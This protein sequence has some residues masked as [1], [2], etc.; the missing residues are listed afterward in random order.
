MIAAIDVSAH[1]IPTL[2]GLQNW[3][4][5]RVQG[6]WRLQE[7]ALSGRCRLLDDHCRCHASGDFETCRAA[8]DRLAP[9]QN[10]GSVVLMLHGL[11]RT[12]QIFRK[13]ARGLEAEGH[14]VYR[15]SWP[16]TRCGFAIHADHLVEILNGLPAGSTV[17]FVTFSA[18]GPLLR[19]ALA[20]PGAWASRLTLGPTVM[21]GPPNRGSRLA[22]M[23]AP[24]APIR[25]LHGPLLKELAPERAGYPPLPPHTTIIAGGR[26]R[27]GWAGFNPLLPDDND[28]M[29][30]LSEACLPEAERTVVLPAWH[31][32]LINHPTTIATVIAALRLPSNF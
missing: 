7:H 29:V 18:G 31:G 1:P 5:R 20:R 2:G 8:M 21:I 32:F 26:G 3:A 6:G 28:G 17:C 22:G 25:W 4:D 19:I 12:R 9:P 10:A 13:L 11:G 23:V 14:Q 30:C 16:S 27:R 15:L 24:W